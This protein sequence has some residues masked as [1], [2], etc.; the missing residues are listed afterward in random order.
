MAEKNVV[1]QKYVFHDRRDPDPV[2]KD[3]DTS[4]EELDN[5]AIQQRQKEQEVIPP[6]ELAVQPILL[7]LKDR[8]QAVIDAHLP[9]MDQIVDQM[10][11]VSIT[12]ISYLQASDQMAKIQNLEVGES[13]VRAEFDVKLK[14]ILDL[15]LAKNDDQIKAY[16]KALEDQAKLHKDTTV[17]KE[18]QLNLAKNI[19]Q[20]YKKSLPMPKFVKRPDNLNPQ[21]LLPR[22]VKTAAGQFD[23]ADE[24]AN[25]NHMWSKL[26]AFG[27]SNFY[28]EEEYKMALQF[29]LEG[30]AYDTF[31]QMMEDERS[32]EYIIN[33]YAQIYGKKRSAA[34]D[35]LALDQFVRKKNEPIDICMHR[36][37]IPI[38]RLQHI[39]SKEHWPEQRKTLQRIILTQVISRDTCRH[40]RLEEEDA[41]EKTGL[42]IDIDKLI[43]IVRRYE[44]FHDKVPS[45]EVVAPFQAASGG[46]IYNVEHLQNENRELKKQKYS[47]EDKVN[48]IY[49]ILATATRPYKNEGKSRDLRESRRS[50]RFSGQRDARQSSFDKNRSLTPVPNAISYKKQATPPPL[51]PS[52]VKRREERQRSQ[53]LNRTS[54]SSTPYRPPSSSL[55]RQTSTDRQREYRPYNR[56]Q[57]GQRQQY[58]RDR[59]RPRSRTPSRTRG[60]E[61]R[62]NYGNRYP[63]RSPQRTAR[64]PSRYP[65][66]TEQT[67]QRRKSR[68]D[69]HP[70]QGAPSFDKSVI[71]NINGAD[72]ADNLKN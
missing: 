35:N 1:P 28:N 53:S 52:L 29:I 3:I 72:S 23:P 61:G 33:H 8:V 4:D 71:L 13:K 58:S 15:V 27:E 62:Q 7:P 5:A 49:E 68:Y 57:S 69:Q 38:D 51:P 40:L 41:I 31:R 14:E 54:R 64:S 67:E 6:Q 10:E 21:R 44:T 20:R 43:E 11:K 16:A 46:L 22:E 42:R 56:D 47:K 45:K 59:Q 17:E 26:C 36:A 37:L 18:T 2:N 65:E 19:A 55:D 39:Y 63:S 34:K 48:E 25:F 66:R 50:E 24:R 32:L 12:P 30:D 60:Y 9:K 70:Q